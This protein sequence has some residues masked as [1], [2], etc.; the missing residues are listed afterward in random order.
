MKKINLLFAT[1]QN[2]IQHVCVVLAS[3]FENNKNESFKIYY[4][5]DELPAE[6]KN[7]LVSFVNSYKS[8]IE[9]I[10][11][12]GSKFDSMVTTH[13]FSKGVY[14]RLM[15]AELIK[16]DKIL[17]LDADLVV[18]ENIAKLYETDLE[19]NYLAA[20]INP[21]FN[22]HNELLMNHYSKYFNCGVL[23]VN[24]NLW[25]K[26]KVFEKSIEYMRINKSN[27]Q[28][29]DQDV[30]N[31][32]VDGNWKEISPIYNQQAVFFENDENI[33]INEFDDKEIKLTKTCPIIVH[34][35]GSYK[36]WNLRYKHPFKNMYWKYLFKTPFFFSNFR[37]Y[38]TYTFIQKLVLKNN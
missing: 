33:Y 15:M 27:I 18:L 21:N 9:F 29:A 14:Y 12:D 10:F 22:R 34:F 11:I 37:K 35:S 3:V 38:F 19:D 17:Y 7:K 28:L 36:P 4:I 31:A 32:I 6:S 8:E 24:L 25:S 16:E 23:L 2:Y 20:V 13:H 26:N 5:I 30:L 1:D